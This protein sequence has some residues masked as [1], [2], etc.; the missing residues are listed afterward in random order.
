MMST[1]RPLFPQERTLSNDFW[2][3]ALGQEQTWQQLASDVEA[4]IGLSGG[5]R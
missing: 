1:S 2:T 5:A 4:K 3:S